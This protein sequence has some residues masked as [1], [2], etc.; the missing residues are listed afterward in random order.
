CDAER[1]I[2]PWVVAQSMVVAAA[3]VVWPL[4]GTRHLG[5]AATAA[6]GE[7]QLSDHGAFPLPA[8]V[9]R[10]GNSPVFRGTGHRRVAILA[11]AA[12]AGLSASQECARQQALRHF[13]QSLSGRLRVV[14]PVAASGGGAGA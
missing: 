1:F 5:F 3:G 2:L 11:R 4:G 7:P 9:D 8:G 13:A 10:A 14:G 6:H 12:L